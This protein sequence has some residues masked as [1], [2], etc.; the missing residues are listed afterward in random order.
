MSRH[1]ARK[2]KNFQPHLNNKI[3]P[4][5][6]DFKNSSSSLHENNKQI[7]FNPL[8]SLSDPKH[9]P[10]IQHLQ[11]IHIDE[12]I[13]HNV[14]GGKN[15]RALLM[16]EAF[17]EMNSKGKSKVSKVSSS[18]DKNQDPLISDI[19]LDRLYNTAWAIEFLQAAFLVADD[20]MDHSETR[21]GKG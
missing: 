3:L 7:I 16:M 10:C 20:I 1:F 14:N 17:Y 18:N 21:R 9:S 13:N 2:F 19:D 8:S 4:A 11:N 15:L 6:K 12:V 5:L